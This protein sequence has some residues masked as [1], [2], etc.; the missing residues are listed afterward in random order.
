MK[1][2]LLALAM[3]CGSAFSQPPDAITD[4]TAARAE[5][6]DVDAQMIAADTYDLFKKYKQAAYWYTK[7]A[8]QGN[9]AAQ[10]YL[11]FYYEKGNGVR[12]DYKQAAYW[13][14]KAAEQGNAGA[15]YNLANL[16]KNG[17][18]VLE[19]HKQAVYWYTKA[20][21][22]GLGLAQFNL[23]ICYA[24]GLG[25]SKDKIKAYAILLHAKLNGIDVSEVDEIIEI[26]SLTPSQKVEG[27]QLA[28]KSF[29]N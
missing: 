23:G 3:M 7:A 14:T 2:I 22:Q 6:G 4:A 20:A 28:K 5:Q 1:R 10:Y 19:D 25:V 8:E 24:M 26:L 29:K 11:G 15:Q 27:Q 9:A 18:G 16:L 13:Y 17:T 21:K 12:Q